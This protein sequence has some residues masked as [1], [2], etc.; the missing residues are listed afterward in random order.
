MVKVS[1][2]DNEFAL[3][4]EC[5]F[6]YDEFQNWFEFFRRNPDLYLDVRA[7]GVEYE[8]HYYLYLNNKAKW[9]SDARKIRERM[10]QKARENA[11]KNSPKANRN[12]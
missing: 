8:D 5:E 10:W 7:V 1:F 6:E 4:D 3:T 9:Y 12:R 2:F 11:K